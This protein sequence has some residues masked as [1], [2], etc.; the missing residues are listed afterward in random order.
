M[1]F[2]WEAIS[3]GGPSLCFHAS[4]IVRDALYIHGGVTDR[5][6]SEPSSNLWKFDFSSSS[7]A[8]IESPGSPRLSHHTAVTQHD[9]YLILIGGWTGK[10]RTA[11]VRIFN[12][13]EEKWFMPKTAG[14][15]VGA[16]LSSHTATSLQDGNIM[17]TGREG[18]LRTQR[19]A[20]STFRLSGDASRRGCSFQYSDTSVGMASRSGHTAAPLTRN[21]LALIGGRSDSLLE[22]LLRVPVAVQAYPELSDK[23]SVLTKKMQP[24]TKPPG[25][26]KN[27]VS[28]STGDVVVVHGGE[29]F[30]GK[31]KA[32]VADL[33]LMGT[34]GGRLQWLK[35]EGNGGGVARAAHVGWVVKD[36]ILIHGGFDERGKT[37][38]EVIKLVL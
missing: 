8:Q 14:F 1:S 27:H 26:R 33:W 32:A 21:Q 11:E 4:A 7:W 20:G 28:V 29:T 22:Y 18:G 24:A 37:R 19:R 34:H 16:G 15:P 25:G 30:D 38:N 31:A 10:S 12:C 17:V 3:T 5:L 35:V 6:S 36:T 2:L 9:Q 13:L 23:L